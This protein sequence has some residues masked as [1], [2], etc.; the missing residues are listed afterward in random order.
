MVRIVLIALALA[1]AIYL[2]MQIVREAGRAEID[3]RGV[4]AVAGFVLL[5]FYLRQVTD[6]GGLV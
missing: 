1:A 4:A 5:A 3:W 6:I 2:V